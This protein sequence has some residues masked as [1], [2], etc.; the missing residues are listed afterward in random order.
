MRRSA[1]LAFV[2]FVAACTSSTP[3]TAPPAAPVEGQTIATGTFQGASDHATTGG[4]SVVRLADG[5]YAV[6]LGPDFSLDGAPDPVVGFGADGYLATSKLGPLEALTGRQAYEVPASL[7]VADFN[8]VHIW[9]EAFSVPLGVA[10]LEPRV[11]TQIRQARRQ[12]RASELD[13]WRT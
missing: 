3:Q 7:D 8:E 1:L 13:G 6:E 9:C 2:L 11:S 12:V 5:S 10:R 4:V